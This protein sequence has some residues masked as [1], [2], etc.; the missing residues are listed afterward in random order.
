MS[1]LGIVTNG[2]NTIAFAVPGRGCVL[3]IK[4]R[5]ER[6]PRDILYYRPGAKTE[7]TKRK[8]KAPFTSMYIH[9]RIEEEIESEKEEL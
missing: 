4:I 6:R 2:R 8:E 3:P 7:P 1:R 9:T 5:G